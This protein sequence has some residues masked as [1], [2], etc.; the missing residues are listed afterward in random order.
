M[1][2]INVLGH[3]KKLDSIRDYEV[4]NLPCGCKQYV[5]K[6]ADCTVCG[7]K[8]PPDTTIGIMELGSQKHIGCI[9]LIP[10]NE[11]IDICL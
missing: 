10:L 4:S 6:D 8:L 5:L 3:D 11:E 2:V 7:K 1:L 9:E